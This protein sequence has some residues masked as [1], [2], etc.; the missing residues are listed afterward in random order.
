ME[1]RFD[2]GTRR[3]GAKGSWLRLK[4]IDTL[5]V[6]ACGKEAGE[7]ST[8]R[9]ANGGAGER[10]DMFLNRDNRGASDPSVPSI[11]QS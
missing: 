6:A 5:P 10:V 9:A 8:L 4:L 7:D 11:G 1:G 2:R 3:K